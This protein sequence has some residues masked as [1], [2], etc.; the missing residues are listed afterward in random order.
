MYL[1]ASSLVFAWETQQVS[2]LVGKLKKE[3]Q[4]SSETFTTEGRE[5]WQREALVPC[6]LADGKAPF[7]VEATDTQLIDP[8]YSCKRLSH[9]LL[10]IAKYAQDRERY[11]KYA[12]LPEPLSCLERSRSLTASSRF[13]FL[14]T[15]FA[16]TEISAGVQLACRCSTRATSTP[17][18][19][20]HQNHVIPISTTTCPNAVLL[21]ETAL[22]CQPS[23]AVHLF[24]GWMSARNRSSPYQVP[25]KLQWDSV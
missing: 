16:D 23:L 7:V 5:N 20:T 22:S 10:G 9:H 19:Q 14:G 24:R 13:G 6:V 15:A 2:T 4:I 3:Y 17:S 18:K 1:F 11:A 8:R 25:G 12:S 21:D